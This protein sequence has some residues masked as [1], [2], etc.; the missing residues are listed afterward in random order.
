LTIAGRRDSRAGAD[1]ETGADVDIG[2]DVD[3]PLGAL[4]A[5][6][7]TVLGDASLGG[8]AACRALADATDAW[9]A[10]VLDDATDGRAD[11]LALVAAGGYG[12]GELAPGSDLDV[13]LLHGG[14]PDVA[15]VARR[16]WYPIWDAG[17]KLGHAVFTPKEALSLAARDLDTAT[18]ALSVRHVAGD[19]IV[20]AGFA[21][22]AGAQ[23]RKRAAGWV[24]ELD[25]RVALRHEACGEVAFLL[26]PDIKEGR[27]GLRDVHALRWA[28][29][30][31]PVLVADDELALTEAEDVLLDIRV[32]LHRLTHRPTDELALELQDDV[33]GALGLADAD[34]VMAHVS[35]AARTVGW[36]SDE[37]WLRIR[38]SLEGPLRRALR[39]DHAL[40]PGLQLR[41]G[42]LHVDP[43]VDISADPSFVL[44]AAAVAAREAV[45]IDRSSLN[46]MGTVAPALD[47]RWP[48]EARD[49]LVG[50]LAT[51]HRAVPVL[52]ALDQRRL[53]E[54]VLPEW[55][56]TRSR[57]QRNALHR[58]TVDRH[59]CETAA[60]AASM[61]GRVA[62][63]DLLLVG[64][65][66]HDIG[67][68]QPGDHL[69]CG[70]TLVRRIGERMGF[71]TD[72]VEML[73]ALVRHHLL[74]VDVATRRDLAD[75]DVAREVA[76]AIGSLELLEL[77]AA[78]TEADA[79]ATGP[80]AWGPWKAEL[81]AEL[82]E[83]VAA[84]LRGEDPARAVQRQGFPNAGVRA[85]MEARRP[86]V[87]SDPPVITVVGPDRP[88][89]FS[90]IAGTLALRGLTVLAAEAASDDGMAASRFR[91][92]AEA[93]EPEWDVV[94]A[95]IRRALD[96][97][98]A[99]E[100]RLAGRRGMH[101][102]KL[103][104]QI[105]VGEPTVRLDNQASGTATVV[106]V[107]GPDRVGVLYRITRA[108]ADLDLDIRS[109]KVATLGDEVIDTF[110]VC[111]SGG[112]K[113]ID[114][115][116]LREVERAIL[117]QLALP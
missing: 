10:A 36:V 64:A 51:G 81:V 45:P 39:R 1:I 23:W 46:R 100:A 49:A 106:E 91:V 82:V 77:L 94:T 78:L 66:L 95:D 112:A 71:P 44:R 116:H 16:I 53:V 2:T 69:R 89:V 57:P 40:G 85:L 117:H 105:L 42:A 109:A 97:H 43:E 72:D 26:E 87:R 5:H 88:G 80:S 58:F 98:L 113:V 101:R 75:D 103:R 114:P 83:R 50:L 73:V 7:T 41:D 6:R 11:G 33:A 24:A 99:I 30:A 108:L 22:R 56:G 28:E 90:R 59:L 8:R 93:L 32:A 37:A 19:P 3:T 55:S 47:R 68:S 61:T 25:H 65:W 110:Y 92:A 15:D 38:A 35:A 21:E 27:G 76:D 84:V 20:S 60:N 13:W 79:L 70:V 31:H 4:L 17:L 102:R 12:R 52:E 96:G 104:R 107:R 9:L 63:P 34:A 111:D 115:D 54:R 48:Q 86:V 62:R 29:R 14:R 74:L 18:A 67:K